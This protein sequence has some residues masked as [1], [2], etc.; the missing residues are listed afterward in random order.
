MNIHPTKKNKDQYFCKKCETWHDKAEWYYSKSGKR[1]SMCKSCRKSYRK[2]AK[3]LHSRQYYQENKE[4]YLELH[5]QWRENN[6]ELKLWHSCK[7]SAK[8]RNLEFDIEPTDIIVPVMCPV[9]N[10]PLDTHAE[11]GVGSGHDWK[12]NPYRPSVDRINNSK[13]YVKGNIEV[14]S[15][16]A[17]SLKKDASLNEIEMLYNHMKKGEQN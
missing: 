3:K 17:N 12:I 8:Q 9:L 10:I 2:D 4:H 14:I 15:W 1:D 5:R 11:S 7:N 16:R 13:G 6:V